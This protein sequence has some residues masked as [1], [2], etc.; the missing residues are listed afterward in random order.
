MNLIFLGP[1]GAGKG[2]QAERVSAKQGIPQLS[3]GDMLR[4][5]VANKTDIGNKAKSFMDA[6]ELVPDAVVVGIIAD[7]IAETDC[8]HGF[9]LDG[10]PRNPAQAKALDD[11]LAERGFALDTVIE[12]KVD[13]DI[14]VDRIRKRAEETG[15]ARSDD[16]VET[17]K[18]RLAVYREQTEPLKP[19]YEARGKLRSIDGMAT[20]DDVS[21]AIDAVLATLNPIRANG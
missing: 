9:I 16:N 5:A 20:I 10:F 4:A 17:L 3:T 11:M 6:G 13:E 18:K 2:T 14:L 7:R 15:G 21:A 12:L 8:A 1:P 19:Y